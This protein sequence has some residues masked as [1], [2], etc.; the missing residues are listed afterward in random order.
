MI[1]DT[2]PFYDALSDCYREYAQKRRAYHKAVDEFIL[3]NAPENVNHLL[4]VG[5]GDGVRGTV[6]AGRLKASQVVFCEPSARM[7]Q[8]CMSANPTMIWNCKAEEMP[9]SRL[10]FD[11]I[12]CLWNVMGHIGDHHKRVLALR[13]MRNML[14][15]TGAIFMDVNNRHNA[16]AYG[17]AK[18]VSRVL[19]D[20]IAFKEHRGDASYCLNVGQKNI[21]GYGHLFTP[22]EIERLVRASK[23]RIAKRVS[24]DY[25]CGIKRRST[26]LGQLVYKVVKA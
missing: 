24:F 22:F 5:A 2:N 8:A 14:T 25:Q 26:L 4:D 7:V 17:I 11:V 12:L 10:K 1:A 9:E 19:I 15:D 18:V 23:L 16:K 3:S 6:L 21:N 20:R 13:R